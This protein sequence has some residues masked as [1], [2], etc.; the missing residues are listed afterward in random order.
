MEPRKTETKPSTPEDNGR[1][2]GAL[3]SS[4]VGSETSPATAAVKDAASEAAVDK[5]MAAG[6]EAHQ[7]AAAGAIMGRS[8]AEPTNATLEHQFWRNEFGKRP[9]VTQGSLY[10]QYAPAFQY[11]WE[12]QAA[13]APKGRTFDEAEPELR[14]DW[15]TRCGK[16]KLSWENAKEA[17]RDAWSRV[18]KQ[19]AGG[20]L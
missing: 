17:T 16:S 2:A 14:R 5:A 20:L 7:G 3:Y 13:F 15:G 12:S 10:D 9:Y 6:T 8:A 1:M 4:P 19:S 11:G 18:E